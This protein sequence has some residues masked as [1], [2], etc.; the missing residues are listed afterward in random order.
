LRVFSPGPDPGGGEQA[1][2]NQTVLVVVLAGILVERTDAPA[3]PAQMPEPLVKKCAVD[4]LLTG[5]L[6]NL[7]CLYPLSKKSQLSI[8]KRRICRVTHNFELLP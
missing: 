3:H 4:S 6:L 7:T 8:Q 1:K 2:G 5:R